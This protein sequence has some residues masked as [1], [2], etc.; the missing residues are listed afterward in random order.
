LFEFMILIFFGGG[1]PNN[2][3]SV[4]QVSPENYTTSCNTVYVGK[5]YHP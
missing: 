2:I 3:N 4:Q 1:D 5:K